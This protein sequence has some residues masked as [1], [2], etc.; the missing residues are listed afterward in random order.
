MRALRSCLLL[1]VASPLFAQDFERL[2]FQ[3]SDRA[4]TSDMPIDFDGD[5]DLDLV[6]GRSPVSC[7]TDVL[8]FR[9][10][11]GKFDQELLFSFDPAN[12]CAWDFQRPLDANGDGLLDLL[13]LSWHGPDHFLIQQADGSFVE[14]I[15]PTAL[16]FWGVDAADVDGDGDA[17]LVYWGGDP[18]FSSFRP[19]LL[20]ANDGSG[21][22]FDASGLF[23]D[24]V[25]SA[26]RFFDFDG[27]G[28]FDILRDAGVNAGVPDD[29]L[30][31]DGAGGLRPLPL[32]ML[33]IPN[34]VG[35]WEVRDLEADGDV[36]VFGNPGLLNLGDGRLVPFETFEAY[37]RTYFPMDWTGE[38][39]LDFVANAFEG[40][41]CE[42]RL[43]GL[44]AFTWDKQSVSDPLLEAQLPADWLLGRD[45]D[46]DGD[47]DL[48]YWGEYTPT[49]I[50]FSRGPDGFESR[51]AAPDLQATSDVKL[52]DA[53]GDGDADAF[54]SGKVWLENDGSGGRWLEHAVVP[55]AFPSGYVL[56]DWDQDG[57]LDEAARLRSGSSW[58]MGLFENDGAGSFTDVS[59][60]LPVAITNE[61]RDLVA[62]D[63]DG[64]G[65][66]DLLVMSLG[67]EFLLFGNGDGTFSDASSRVSLPNKLMTGALA[68]LDMDGDLDAVLQSASLFSVPAQA[69]LYDNPGDGLLVATTRS[70]ETARTTNEELADLDADGAVDLVT[71]GFTPRPLDVYPADGSGF[72]EDA[73]VFSYS[74]ASGAPGSV[75]DVDEDGQL[76]L[77]LGGPTYLRHSGDF[78]FED[79]TANIRS[80][81][82]SA[83]PAAP[84][85]GDLDLDG[86]LDLWSPVS[87]GLYASTRIYWNLERQVAWH[88]WPQ[89]GTSLV[90]DVRGTPDS[91]YGLWASL[92]PPLPGPPTGFRLD[93]ADASLVQVSDLDSSGRSLPSLELPAELSLVGEELSWQALI[94]VPYGWSNVERTVLGPP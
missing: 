27:D 23:P 47:D 60:G 26:A 80:P 9:N 6:G 85:A 35:V 49:T 92:Q 79:R 81:T 58:D 76:D 13:L 74:L 65:F 69:V 22:F 19:N 43:P 88:L 33:G 31:N 90:L 38:R 54:S 16:D 91:P 82:A 73:P 2:R 1:V 87:S 55:Q 24:E 30:V 51:Y 48:L 10:H 14:S 28:D 93:P 45:W 8:L 25:E 71:Y 50:L 86:D 77:L 84:A 52:A 41:V 94:G 44:F 64:D 59:S 66:P 63:I 15:S 75:V 39:G 32:Y 83:Y 53:D 56:L 37:S 36:D 34:I 68:D 78:I 70:V 46:S 4:S 5:G 57:D 3:I 61:G 67:P 40:I 62:G 89:A 42:C 20:L 11:R 17:D 7:A 12:G 72:F 29:L 18:S 21:S